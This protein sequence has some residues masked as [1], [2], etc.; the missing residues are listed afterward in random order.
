MARWWSRDIPPVRRV[1]EAV[2]MSLDRDIQALTA[3]VG[4]TG[5]E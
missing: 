1:N 3:R 4:G 2:T 5:R